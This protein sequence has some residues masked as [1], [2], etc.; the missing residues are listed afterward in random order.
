MFAFAVT[1]GFFDHAFADVLLVYCHL[2]IDYKKDLVN[3]R[4]LLVDLSLTS[5]SN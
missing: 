2:N 3:E 1:G 4:I 5:T